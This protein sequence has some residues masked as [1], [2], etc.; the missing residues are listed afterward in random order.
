MQGF[1]CSLAI[2]ITCVASI[3]IFDFTVSLQFSLG[4]T[5][6]IS[7]IFLYGWQ[8]KPAPGRPKGGVGQG[9]RAILDA[10]PEVLDL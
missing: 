1:A 5:L 6:V 9:T 4:A 2:I 8:P 7:S 3:F 10:L